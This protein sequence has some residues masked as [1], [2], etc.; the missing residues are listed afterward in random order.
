M[1]VFWVAFKVLISFAYAHML[2]LFDGILIFKP[3]KWDGRVFSAVSVWWVTA[4]YS[5]FGLSLKYVN[6]GLFAKKFDSDMPVMILIFDNGFG[7]PPT[8]S[9]LPSWISHLLYGF[10]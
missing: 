8:F 7:H 10:N 9:L 4:V 5:F 1:K 2:I 3:E 6:T